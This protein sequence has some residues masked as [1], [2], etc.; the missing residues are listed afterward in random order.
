[1]AKYHCYTDGYESVRATDVDA[2]SHRQAAELAATKLGL[3]G[4][5]TVL[6]G[7][8]VQVQVHVRERYEAATERPC[9]PARHETEREDA[10][11]SP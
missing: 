5:W 2:D 4:T 8:P 6:Q 11:L 7:I 1:M 10:D 9:G 3:A